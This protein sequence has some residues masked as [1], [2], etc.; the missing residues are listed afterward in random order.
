[1]AQPRM[2]RMRI[3]ATVLGAP[4]PQALGA[5]Y[6]RFLG[7]MV[8]ESDHTWTRVM[9]PN[10]GPGLSFQRESYFVPPVWPV[11]QGAQQM[12]SHLDIAVEDLE[13]AVAWA[14]D[15]GA[16]LAEHQP[17]EMVRV[18]RDPA[19]HVFCLFTGEV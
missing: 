10:G 16:T 4:D 18:M 13:A 5:F 9:P 3:S 15:A 11:K 17:Q 19:G 8:A 2:P 7:W 6:A 1:M 12:M 14:V